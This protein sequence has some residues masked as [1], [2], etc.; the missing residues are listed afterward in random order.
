MNKTL[1]LTLTLIIN[2]FIMPKQALC[3]QKEKNLWEKAV[4]SFY[5][6]SMWIPGCIQTTENTYD[7]K[8]K[9]QETEKLIF[10]VNKKEKNI[11]LSKAF[12]NNHTLSAKELKEINSEMK[13]TSIYEILHSGLNPFE[14]TYQ[15]NI[16]A[17]P[18]KETIEANSKI[19]QKFTYSQNTQD[20]K[21]TGVAWLEKETGRP[22][23]IIASPL[24]LS[25]QDTKDIIIKKFSITVHY[26]EFNPSSW[27]IH[28]I[29]TETLFILH[30]LPWISF[31]GISK[32]TAILSDFFDS[33]STSK[34]S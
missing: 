4:K 14:A 34:T 10:K 29:Y 11:F 33:S 21:W 27:H 1:F 8:G 3:M 23:K 6:G 19:Y 25:L 26:K 13:E 16:I 18:C 31:E 24:D 5:S 20:A 17:T 9:L 15:S 28:K 2:T 32:E 12:L 22:L 7:L 30:E